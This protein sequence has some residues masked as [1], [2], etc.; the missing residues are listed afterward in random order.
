MRCA[1]KVAEQRRKLVQSTVNFPAVLPHPLGADAPPSPAVPAGT[2]SLIPSSVP[3]TRHGM[4]SF[5]ELGAE[6]PTA[7][8]DTRN[9]TVALVHDPRR[10]A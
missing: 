10:L 5:S 7:E 3:G 8:I 6:G 9:V 4:P 2:L 1:Q